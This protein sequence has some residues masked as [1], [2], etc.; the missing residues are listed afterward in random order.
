MATDSE[1]MCPNQ[2]GVY[3]LLVTKFV[4]KLKEI[5]HVLSEKR[6]IRLKMNLKPLYAHRSFDSQKFPCFQRII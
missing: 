6:K 1:L 4:A 3:V 5:Y 2:K